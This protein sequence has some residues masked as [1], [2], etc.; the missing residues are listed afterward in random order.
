ML[1]SITAL[2]F[3]DYEK[4]CQQMMGVDGVRF[5][6]ERLRC[7]CTKVCGVTVWRHGCM[8]CTAYRYVAFNPSFDEHAGTYCTYP[9]K[10]G[11]VELI[12]RSI[13]FI[14][15]LSRCIWPVSF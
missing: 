14:V 6:G 13:S 8:G 4:V 12:L 9:G 1:V 5:A 3:P 10:D 7:V 15:G 11:Q 2:I